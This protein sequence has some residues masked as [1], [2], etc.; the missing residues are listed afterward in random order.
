MWALASSEREE[1]E[2]QSSLVQPYGREGS[3]ERS[4]TD[5]K[6]L[7]LRRRNVSRQ[8]IEKGL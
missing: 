5:R 7:P 2:I 8:A 4:L 6:R 1:E 3:V